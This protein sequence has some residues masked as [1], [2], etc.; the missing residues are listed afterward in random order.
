MGNSKINLSN[1]PNECPYCHKFIQPIE[2]YR[3]G[4]NEGVEIVFECVNIECGKLF[5]AYYNVLDGQFLDFRNCNIGTF[6]E[7]SFE[8]VINEISPSFVKIYNEAYIAEQNKL[9]EIC[10][11]GYRKAIDFLIKDY[12]I[13]KKP[14]NSLIIIN[15]FLGNCFRDDISDLK[16]KEVAS[17]VIWLDNDETHF[18]RNWNEKNIKELKNLIM[19]IVHWLKM[20]ELH[21][22]MLEEM[23]ELKK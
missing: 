12:L 15:K 22:T 11:V 19:L 9:L 6:K 2:R 17:R 18:V 8:D 20:E 21:K 1:V 10:G 3:N 13:S 7:I 14:E 16:I 4:T 23:T 5:I